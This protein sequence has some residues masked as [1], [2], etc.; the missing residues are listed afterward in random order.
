MLGERGPRLEPTVVGPPP[1]I[2]VARGRHSIDPE[3]VVLQQLAAPIA[4]V[5]GRVGEDVDVLVLGRVHV[6]AES[7]ISH[8]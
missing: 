5:E 8:N 6:V 3:L 2:L 7:A 4:V 1:N